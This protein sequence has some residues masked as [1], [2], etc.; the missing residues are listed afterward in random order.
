MLYA[1]AKVCTQTCLGLGLTWLLA[2]LANSRADPV[3]HLPQAASLFGLLTLVIILSA[4]TASWY[5]L[6][7]RYDSQ[8]LLAQVF[9][10]AFMSAFVIFEACFCLALL[11]NS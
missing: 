1:M 6:K 10:V 3:L 2:C 5:L 4:F 8:T 9:G 11:R 7:A